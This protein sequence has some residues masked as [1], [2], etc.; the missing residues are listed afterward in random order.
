M[1]RTS[2]A[3]RRF[4][5][6]ATTTRRSSSWPGARS[7]SSSTPAASCPAS[8]GSRARPR[9]VR[10]AL[11]LRV[12]HQC[13]QRHVAGGAD[14]RR[15][16]RR[17]DL[18]PPTPARTTA[19]T[20]SSRPVASGLSPRSSASGRRSPAPASSSARTRTSAASPAWLIRMAVVARCWRR[21]TPTNRPSWSTCAT[22]HGSCSTAASTARRGR[23]TPPPRRPATD[24]IGGCAQTAST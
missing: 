5:A 20:A 22:S 11:R 4:G 12:Q 15:A 16:R 10:R 21:G 1:D 7:T 13:D 17:Q 2:R 19:T 9:G 8:S 23:S 24:T 14:A 3:S 6:T 18:P